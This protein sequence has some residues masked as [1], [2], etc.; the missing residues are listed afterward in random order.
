MRDNQYNRNQGSYGSQGGSSR[1]NYGSS[2]GNNDYGSSNYGY[3][4]GSGS[5][6]GAMVRR[7]ALLM[8]AD[9]WAVMGHLREAMVRTA[10]PTWAAITAI[11]V[12]LR[13]VHRANRGKAATAAMLRV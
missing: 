1:G 10:A 3:G 9:P 6:Y 4:Q 2:Q 5:S 7:A 13:V 11:A 8:A 12:H